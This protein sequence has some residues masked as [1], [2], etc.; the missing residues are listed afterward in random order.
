[1]LA[2]NIVVAS[3]PLAAQSGLRMLA[4][5]GNAVD[6]AVAAAATLAVVEPVN[7]SVGGD[8]FA[9]VWHR[10]QLY[11]VNG[12]GRSPAGWRA[13][14]FAGRSAMPVRGWDSVTVPGAVSVWAELSAR[15]GRL[16]FDALLAPAIGYA[17][18][19]YAVTPSVAEKWLDQAPELAAQ[20]G[21][22]QAFLPQGRAPRIGERFQ[23]PGLA[24]TLERIAATRGRDFYE[25]ETAARIAH[26]A[27]ECGAALAI[28]DL[29]S[30]RAEWTRPLAVRYRGVD[31]HE[32]P[33]NG[34]GIV[35]LMALG[36][37]EHF[38]MD[39][40]APDSAPWIHLQI[41]A[42][43]LAFADAAHYVAEP[44]AMALDVMRLLEPRYLAARAGLIDRQ[45]AQV[46][47]HG[48]PPLAGTV[49]LAA[50]DAAGTM[51][52]LIQSNYMGFG[53]GVVVPGIGVALQNRGAGFT[54]EPSHAN[55]VGP[56]K[57]PYH[58]ILPGFGSIKG[59]P[60]LALGSTGGVFQPQ[61]HVQAV[62]R[63]VDHRQ[64]PQAIV[65][66]P[67]FRVADGRR[68]NLEPGF[69]SEVLADLAAMG[70]E[71]HA[72]VESTWDFGGMQM[73]YRLGE[74]YVGACDARRDSQAAGF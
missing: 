63:L 45:R 18:E 42:L 33:P 61:G 47:G 10:G 39:G 55:C 57:R 4:D 3:Q 58:T 34:Q 56:G 32:L 26:F 12:S 29:S 60:L 48:M 41:E 14:R 68:V 37:L 74:D 16:P 71:I 1:V 31:V 28:E 44:E 5:G 43:K 6:A 67:R 40:L 21:F 15:F 52:S 70:H 11:G 24:G 2:R 27:G 13:Q 72:Q 20:P 46:C 30:H 51:V 35:A 8:A 62:V 19:G 53:S 22:A 25:G 17:R 59:T 7:N 49:Y 73:I 66:A 64:N 50:A 38:E 9:Q 54:L 69:R 65:D 23:L 36:M